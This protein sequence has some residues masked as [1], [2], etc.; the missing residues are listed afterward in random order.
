MPLLSAGRSPDA[1][2]ATGGY[3]RAPLDRRRLGQSPETQPVLFGLRPKDQS[4]SFC[5]NAVVSAA[6]FSV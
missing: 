4:P 6:W 1:S 3:Q 2:R 5:H